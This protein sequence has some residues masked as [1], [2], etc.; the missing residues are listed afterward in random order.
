MAEEKLYTSEEL[1]EEGINNAHKRWDAFI[2]KYADLKRPDHIVCSSEQIAIEFMG[3]GG[4]LGAL[5]H[6][7]IA[8]TDESMSDEMF[9]VFS[10]GFKQ[11]ME[12]A[13]ASER[14]EKRLPN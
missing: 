1:F 4:F 8:Q 12:V 3:C 7:C 2:D 13:K 6:L 11:G 10:L 9:K 5:L 14:A